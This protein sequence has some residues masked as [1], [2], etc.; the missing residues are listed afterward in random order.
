MIFN[1]EPKGKALNIFDRLYLFFFIILPFIYTDKLVDPV[2]IPRQFFLTVFVFIVGSIIFLNARAKRMIIDFTFL[3]LMINVSFIVLLITIGVSFFLSIVIQESIY[4]LSKVAIEFIFFM[5]TT[6]LLIQKKL[7]LNSLI[8][9]VVIFASISLFLALFQ[10]MKL[11][12]SKNDFFENVVYVGATFGIKNLLASILFLCIPFLLHSFNY[13]KVLKI[14]SITVGLLSL[15]LIWLLQTKAVIIAMIVLAFIL[16]IYLLKEKTINKVG[17][18]IVLVSGIIIFF[19]I[20]AVT[21]QNRQKFSHI[22]DKKSSIERLFIWDNSI[23]MVKENF[24]FGV[25]AGNWQIHVPKYGLD[26]CPTYEIREGMRTLQRPHND[27]LWMLCEMGVLGFL[28][29]VSIFILVL[30]YLIQLLIKHKD[31]EYSWLHLCFF[32]TTI[33][34]MIIGFVDFPLERIE[35][36]IILFVILSITSAHYYH[37]FNQFKTPILLQN[38]TFG[39]VFF[40]PVLLS[41]FVTIKRAAGEFHSQKIYIYEHNANWQKL[42]KE[43][44][45]AMSSFYVMDPMSAPIEWYK[46][47]AL[48]SQGNIE[49][50]KI[51]FEKAYS[52]HPYNIHVL[53]NLA[54]CYESLKDHDKAIKFYLKALYIS[55]EFEE[56]RLNL[57]AVYFNMKQFEKSFEVIDQCNTNSKDSKYKLFLS[58]ILSAF[59][60]VKLNQQTDLILK[61]KGLAIVS[62]KEKIVQLYFESK[63]KN[64]K[65]DIYFLNSLNSF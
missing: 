50:A 55:S 21:L 8:Q 22:F 43:A 29:Y 54:S 37:K 65:F 57:S 47:V 45:N 34:Y 32:A 9:S 51:S 64:I 30:Y 59:L 33:G 40:A 27:F 11:A 6:F 5:I 14:F 15:F 62:D 18:K 10:V 25:G 53:N 23:E 4:L 7:N 56:A 2:L 49:V 44:D 58:A 48:F 28:S 60:E 16:L 13:G 3:K 39:L 36:Q 42:I 20:S 61:N 63:A 46:G 19:M 31:H 41:I 24:V 35:H 26:K 1:I 52:I 38:S 17:F 12:L